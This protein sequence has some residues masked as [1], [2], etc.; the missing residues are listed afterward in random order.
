MAR[1]NIDVADAA[2]KDAPIDQIKK[3][4]LKRADV[5]LKNNIPMD[6]GP[7]KEVSAD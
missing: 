2:E 1:S 3:S 4:A 5:T 6:Q 7:N